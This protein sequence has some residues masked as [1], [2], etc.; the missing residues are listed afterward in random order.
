[1]RDLGPL[2]DSFPLGME[3]Y[4][5]NGNL[6]AINEAAKAHFGITG[7][8]SGVNLLQDSTVR[9]EIKAAF[10]SRSLL[11]TR[12]MLD[13]AA[14]GF[15]TTRTEA[16]WSRVRGF[17][18]TADQ[19][20]LYFLVYEDISL[21]TVAREA[22]GG[23]KVRSVLR[24]TNVETPILG[25]DRDLRVILCNDAWAS[26]LSLEREQAEGH[27]V[28]DVDKG[29]ADSEAAH[30]VQD[31]LLHAKTTSL[32]ATREERTYEIDVYPATWGVFLRWRDVTKWLQAQERLTRLAHSLNNHREEESQRLSRE[33]H[34]VVGG[35]LVSLSIALQALERL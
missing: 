2:F 35:N 32:T 14:C 15:P 31:A 3:A 24:L 30:A 23:E 22:F 6:V 34:D 33:L 11:D 12:T 5:A 25:L 29:F 4:D 27:P 17:P 10:A 16:V 1:M 13:P 19:K 8:V 18:G 26:W 9:P 21:R 20:D 7:D 28:W